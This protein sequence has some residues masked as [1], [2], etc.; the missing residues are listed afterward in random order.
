MT[1]EF[2]MPRI[3]VPIGRTNTGALVYF[4]ANFL[5]SFLQQLFGRVGGNVALSNIEL[6]QIALQLAG[7]DIRSSPEAREA[8]R[9][10]DELR[11][12]ISS[13]RSG[14][15][16]LRRLIDEQAGEVVSVRTENGNLHRL[17]NEREAEFAGLRISPDL[18]TVNSTPGT[19]GDSTH[20]PILTIDAKGRTTSVSTALISGGGG[21]TDWFSYS[22]FGGF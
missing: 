19:Y 3:D 18:P 12:E 15:D 21:S 11:N 4:D 6:E 16:G 20:V 2:Q 22:H 5:R 10:V 17:L 9:A 8:T 7:D 13:V 14:C 1:T